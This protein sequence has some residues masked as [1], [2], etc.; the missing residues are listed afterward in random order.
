MNFVLKLNFNNL[1]S[2]FGAF[3]VISLRVS[4][5]FAAREEP[6]A[7]RSSSP[8]LMTLALPRDSE[9]A[10]MR[11][12]V[13]MILLAIAGSLLISAHARAE[14]DDKAALLACPRC[15][16]LKIVDDISADALRLFD[17]DGVMEH[18]CPA[19]DAHVA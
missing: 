16:R 2:K 4:C 1:R 12:A 8:K 11:T 13:W 5:N 7:M 6:R 3:L 15:G 18:E 17:L 9:A 10:T 14:G 19:V